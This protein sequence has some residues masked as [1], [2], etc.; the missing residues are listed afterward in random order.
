MYCREE[1]PCLPHIFLLFKSSHSPLLSP[2]GFPQLVWLCW[3][4][5][6]P[7]QSASSE[8]TLTKL[9]ILFFFSS[10]VILV[11]K[12]VT[13]EINLQETPG[14]TFI[15]NPI[16]ILVLPICVCLGNRISY[17]FQFI[18]Y[19]FQFINRYN[20]LSKLSNLKPLC[21]I[22]IPKI[23]YRLKVSYG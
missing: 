18:S 17:I 19:I 15:H 9:N 16:V 20:I 13:T 1:Q 22:S 5:T 11:L 6:K 2:P 10:E 4:Q 14:M 3:L 12:K 7:Q 8:S 21:L 23:R